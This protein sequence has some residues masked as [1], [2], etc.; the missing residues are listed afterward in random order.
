M[1]N[2]T[3]EMLIIELALKGA[4]LSAIGRQF[5]ISRE[6]VRQIVTR[7]GQ[8]EQAV[9]ARFHASQYARNKR[10]ENAMKLLREKNEP[11]TGVA[12]RRI[13]HVSR[14]RVT[15]A[16]IK[17]ALSQHGTCA[18]YQRGCRCESCHTANYLSICAAINRR[19]LREGLRPI[20]H[21]LKTLT[22][23]KALNKDSS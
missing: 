9:L 15:E 16:G 2:K 20:Q 3:R 14:L 22:R 1:V 23:F 17:R 6:R 5:E 13:A 18:R 19:R 11:I 21:K 4:P 12:V 10:F 7:A 8:E